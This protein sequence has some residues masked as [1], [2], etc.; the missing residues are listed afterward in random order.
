MFQVFWETIASTR[1]LENPPFIRSED[2]YFNPTP[3]KRESPFLLHQRRIPMQVRDS[4]ELHI[5]AGADDSSNS[6]KAT[7]WLFTLLFDYT[8]H[9]FRF[10]GKMTHMVIIQ[11]LSL[12]L[13]LSLQSGRRVQTKNNGVVGMLPNIAEVP[14]GHVTCEILLSPGQS[15]NTPLVWELASRT[16]KY[17]YRTEH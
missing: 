8:M 12:I 14:E 7:V 5:V 4:P 17:N 6:P 1:M 13:S 3:E 15:T 2:G 11:S 10:H 9:H 16:K